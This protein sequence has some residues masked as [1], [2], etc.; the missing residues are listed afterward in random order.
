MDVEGDEDLNEGCVLAFITLL[1]FPGNH[2]LQ[3]DTNI[4]KNKSH[5]KRGDDIKKCKMDTNVLVI[6]EAACCRCQ[7]FVWSINQWIDVTAIILPQAF[8]CPPVH[9]QRRKHLGNV[10]KTSST[11][12]T[13]LY[14]HVLYWLE[15]WMNIPQ[16]QFSCD[17]TALISITWNC[18]NFIST[19]SS[20]A[21]SYLMV[22]WVTWETHSVNQHFSLHIQCGENVCRIIFDKDKFETFSNFH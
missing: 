22:T 21:N 10:V 1:V 12:W 11:R 13:H 9:L 2:T 7:A 6:E 3:S 5:L 16:K 18:L 8:L 19:L 4:K 17:V 14:H 20:L 15:A